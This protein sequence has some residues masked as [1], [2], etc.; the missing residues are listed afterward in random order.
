MSPHHLGG[1]VSGRVKEWLGNGHQQPNAIEYLTEFDVA[2]S[3]SRVA[4]R[5]ITILAIYQESARL[6]GRLYP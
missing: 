1:I 2:V 6:S 4:V 3:K 5:G